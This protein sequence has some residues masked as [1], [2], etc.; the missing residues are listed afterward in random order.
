MFATLST[1]SYIAF[2]KQKKTLKAIASATI[3]WLLFALFSLST[4]GLGYLEV[5]KAKSFVPSTMCLFAS[6]V[7]HYFIH[8][9]ARLL[10]PVAILGLFISSTMT[11]EQQSVTNI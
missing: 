5:Q 3:T 4:T 11:V 1:T 2:V 8:H 7:Q 6:F 10:S 9:T